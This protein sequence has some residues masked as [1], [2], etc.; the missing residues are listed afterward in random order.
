MKLV[1]ANPQPTVAGLE[2]LPG[3][4]N[5]FLGND[6]RRWRSNVPTYRRVKYQQVYPGIDLVYYGQQQLEYD[7]VVAPGADPKSIRLSFVG[8]DKLEVDGEGNL[9]LQKAGGKLVQHAPNIYQEIHGSKRT[10]PGRYFLVANENP[11]LSTGHAPGPAQQVGFEVDSYDPNRT[12][13]IDPVLVYSTYLGGSGS[14]FGS[15]IAVDS[16][17][18]AYV[19]GSTFSPDFPTENPL[20]LSLNGI[21]DVFVAKLNAA[22]SALLYSTYLGGSDNEGGIGIAVDSVGNAYVTGETFSPDFPTQNPLQ[23]ANGGGG[24][25]FVTKLNA[26]GSALL[27]STYLG[28]SGA[29]LEDRGF[30]IAVDPSGNAY[31]TGETNSLDFPTQNPLQSTLNGDVDAFVAKLNAAGSALVY[32]TYLGGSGGEAGHGIAADS[33]GNAY[34]TGTTDSLDFPIQNPLQSALKGISDDFVTKLNAAGSALLYSSYLGGSREEGVNA[35][36]AVDASGNAYVT[37]STRSIDFPTKNPLQPALNGGRNTFATKVNPTGS[38]LVYSTYLGGS[39]ADFG[40]SI[41]VDASGNAYVAGTTFSPDFP[42]QNPLQPAFGGGFFDAF[43]AK[44]DAAGSALVYSTYLGGS[45]DDSCSSIVVDP[46][47]NAYVTGTTFSP[48]FPTQNPLQPGLNGGADAFVAKIA[49]GPVTLQ[50]VIDIKPGGFP[51]SINP[52][53]NGNIPVAIL[54]TD[55]FDANSIDPSTVRFGRTGEEAAPLR[56]RLED[57]D[58][59]RNLDLVLHFATQQTGLQC[60]DS[61]ARLTGET[62]S[63]QPIEGSDSVRTVGCQE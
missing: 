12:L 6:P 1:G 25:V 37:G 20:Q 62:S 34:V 42:T 14:D 35:G 16:A 63:G 2:E 40:V 44:L 31:V 19:R 45:V 55:S 23:P 53:S 17:G 52:R 51:N 9:V 7:L 5:Y 13:V 32:S 56:S 60:G 33:G 21:G 27:Y 46:S 11:Q 38:A 36:I 4:A 43:V 22:G 30:C 50:V 29:G 18:H 58:G 10:I 28:G 54:T 48:D 24:D 3:K 8:A 59:D 41:A 26:A 57:V 15:S 39:I 61:S 49:S 47:G